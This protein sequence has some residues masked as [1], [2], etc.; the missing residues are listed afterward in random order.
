LT[1]TQGGLGNNVIRRNLMRFAYLGNGIQ[2]ENCISHIEDSSIDE[3]MNDTNVSENRCISATDDAFEFDSANLNL[4]V[5]SN[6]AFSSNSGI[7]IAAN[8]VSPAY[9]FRNLFYAP[10]AS[11]AACAG[12]KTGASSTGYAFFYHNTVHYPQRCDVPVAGGSISHGVQSLGVTNQGETRYATNLVF[13]NNLFAV[14]GRLFELSGDSQGQTLT[15][16]ADYNTYFDYDGGV[17]GK[18]GA[19]WDSFEEYQAHPQTDDQHSRDDEPIWR[20]AINSDLAVRDYRLAA[21]SAGVDSGTEIPGFNDFS[22]RWP[23]QDEAP[24]AGAFEYLR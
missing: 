18:R 13:R 6:V 15:F 19:S 21:G 9:F 8:S 12:I 16:D 20:D 5:W 2:G 14:A 22:S 1:V 4:R 17:W 7:S 23:G 10:A 3:S 11:G 24:D